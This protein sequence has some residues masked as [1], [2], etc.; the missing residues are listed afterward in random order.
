MAKDQQGLTLA[1]SS[2]S[3]G[4]FDRAVADYYALG[5]DPVGAL[6]QALAGD[7]E[8]ALGGVAIA[9]L[10]MIGG[11]RGDHPE[12][13]NGLQAA[14]AAIGKASRREKLHLA[15]VKA[16]AAGRASEATL[17]WEAILT[18]WPTDALALR[19]GQDAYYL[20]GQSLAIRDSIARVLPAWDRDNPLTSFVL[21]AYA[22]GLEEAGELQR[23]EGVGRAALAEN[24]RDAW[25]THALAHVMETANRQDEG[26]AF[27]KETRSDWS[28]AHFMA[29]HNGWHLAVYL[30]EQGRFGEV[31]ADFDRFAIPKLADDATLDRVDAASLLWRLELAGVDVGDR[32]GW[33]ARAWMAHVDDHVLAFN[34]LHCALAAA[35]SP[36]SDDVKRLRRSLDDEARRESGHY[37]HVM[38][39]VG[40]PLIEGVLAFADGDYR[41]AV[42][43]ILPARF[44][45]FRI[46]GSHAQRDIVNQTLIVAA[47]RSGQWSLARALLA[48]RLALR[49]TAPTKAAYKRASARA[50]AARRSDH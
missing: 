3:A 18:D 15:A 43:A 39:E 37:G 30:I 8:F 28:P 48:E 26:I 33:V 1:G 14:E 13:V 32:W 35:R 46:G 17:D 42:E 23:A 12:V 50:A 27:L 45:A 2:A 22:F 20:L 34:D 44:V 47:E 7:P 19:F 4:A 24:P 6:K 10:F 40:R 38:V 49:P 5:G 9:G 41:G 31:L 29:G 21:G 36:D 11:F 16:W 25:A